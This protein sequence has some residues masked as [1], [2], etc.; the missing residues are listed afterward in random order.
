LWF[1]FVDES[2]HQPK[3]YL[4]SDIQGATCQYFGI[5]QIEL[6]SRRRSHDV[7]IPRQIAMYLCKQLTTRSLPEIGR[8]FGGM[9]HTTVLNAVRV[10]E[11]RM[12][13]DWRLAFD[14]AHVERTM[15]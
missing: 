6:L 4:V 8:M 9:D 1:C 11:K 2:D 15:A 3:R 7:V 5:T 14:I 12:S 13:K 10:I